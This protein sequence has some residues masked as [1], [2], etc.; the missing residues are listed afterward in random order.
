MARHY[1]LRNDFHGTECRVRCEG[2]QHIYHTVV[3]T[4]SKSQAARAK[5]VLC[6]MHG[7]T[8]SDECGTRGRQYTDLHYADRKAIEIEVA[9]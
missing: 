6:G 3:L 2:L 4:L 8:C 7:C 5:R 1:T 9:R